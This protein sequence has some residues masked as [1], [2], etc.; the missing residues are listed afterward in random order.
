ML[1]GAGI[2]L[3]FECGASLRVVGYRD[4]NLYPT[5]RVGMRA[6]E[7]GA[8]QFTSFSVTVTVNNPVSPLCR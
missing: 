4:S 7:T 6:A 8:R 5:Q 1:G 2:R 3:F